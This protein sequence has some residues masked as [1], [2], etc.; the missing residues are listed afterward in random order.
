MFFLLPMV[1]SLVDNRAYFALNP[2][3]TSCLKQTIVPLA[4]YSSRTVYA[5]VNF[6]W[7]VQNFMGLAQVIDWKPVENIKERYNLFQRRTIVIRFWFE[8][9]YFKVK[10]DLKFNKFDWFDWKRTLLSISLMQ[11][12]F[13]DRT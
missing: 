3:G 12:I 2:G 13:K 9:V 4:A 1:G 10:L 11:S 6:S 8:M 5:F 7:G